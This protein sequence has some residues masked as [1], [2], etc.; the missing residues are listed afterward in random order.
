MQEEELF[1]RSGRSDGAAKADPREIL[2]SVI[3]WR[4][5][6]RWA[7]ATTSNRYRPVTT[8]SPF[9]LTLAADWAT[10]P[11]QKKPT[12]RRFSG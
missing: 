6:K 2:L 10:A 9:L 1:N 3:D 8:S 11:K 7:P 12:G 4:I 5:P